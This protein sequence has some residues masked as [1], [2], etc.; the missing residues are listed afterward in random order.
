M[1]PNDSQTNWALPG[2]N[3]ADFSKLGK[4]QADALANMQQELSRLIEQANSDWLSRVEVER[5]L[6][7][8]LANKLSAAKSPADAA[9]AYQDW[10]GRRMEPMSKDSQK[11]FADSQKFVSSMT[12]FLSGRAQGAST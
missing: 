6:A 12:R 5:N 4:E 2:F 1:P 9:K 3:P 11:F 10:M 7:S 8:D